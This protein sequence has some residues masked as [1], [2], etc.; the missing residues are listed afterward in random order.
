MRLIWSFALGILVL[1]LGIAAIGFLYYQILK[2]SDDPVRIIV[3][4]IISLVVSIPAFFFSVSAGAMGPI[5]I[6]VPAICL[7]IMWAP[8]IGAALASPFSGM[9]DG[10]NQPVEAKP[11]Y[12]IAEAKRKRGD[13]AGALAEIER[14]LEK[15]P[16]D[17][18]GEMMQA[19]IQVEHL[20]NFS[21][22]AHT[23]ERVLAEPEQ[24]PQ[25]IA[26][27]LSQL[28]DWHLKFS[29]DPDQARQALERIVARLPHTAY[30]QTAAQRIGH[31]APK[32]FLEQAQSRPVIHL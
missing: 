22:G 1:V 30:A 20:H 4:T 7:G 31:L 25:H 13:F 10:G 32:E 14:Q 8:H 3:K 16:G 6:M 17:Y 19:S 27:A 21:A 24:S 12:S 23:I 28:A 2:R 29:N 9:F 26:D 18:S 15:F 5:I 11:F